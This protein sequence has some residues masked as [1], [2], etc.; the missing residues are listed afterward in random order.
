MRDIEQ[1][2]SGFRTF[3]S[4]Y[5]GPDSSH[6]ENLQEGQSPKIMIVACS[7]SRVDPAILTNSEPGDIFTVRNIANLVP[8]CEDQ[9]GLHGVSAALEY[10]VSHLKVEHVIVLGHS[11]CGG[12]HALMDGCAD[13][14]EDGF[15]SRWISIAEPVRQ[16]IRMN[17]SHK[18]PELQQRAAEQLSILLSLENLHTF[19]FVMEGIEAGHLSLHGWYFD[20]AR[21]ELSE[22]RA[23]DKSFHPI[24]SA[25]ST[26]V[27]PHD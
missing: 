15:V 21:G 24:R 23:E 4:N 17:L 5:F 7:D 27:L 25:L 19:P 18:A 26:D 10:A 22:Y 6:F 14:R 1:L 20:L 8:P 16:Q 11:Q 2:I 12:I 3:Q 9:G 13:C